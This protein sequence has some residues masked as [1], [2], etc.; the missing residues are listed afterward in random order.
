MPQQLQPYRPLLLAH[1]GAAVVL[2]LVAACSGGADPEGT[3][4]RIVRE[5]EQTLK[6]VAQNELVRDPELATRLGVLPDAAGY[7]FGGYLSDRS[8]AAFE[9][10]RLERLETLDVLVRTARPAP[11]SA[12][13]R[14]LDTV[15]AAHEAAERVLVSGHGAGDLSGFYPYVADHMRG[16]YL[17]VPELL[18][19]R[20]PMETPADVEA[21]LSRASQLA[22]AIDD[23]RRRLDA[24]ARAGVLPPAPILARMQALAASGALETPETSF[25]VQTFDNLLNGVEG[26]S[27]DARTQSAA[28][29]RTIF[30]GD[31]LP[32]YARLAEDITALAES[33]P[34]EPGVWQLEGGDA[35]YRAILDA[36]T[37]TRETPAELHTRGLAD[38][39][40]LT[41]E[42]DAAL[43]A[44]GLPDGTIAE[45][46]IF[47][48]QQPGQF[49]EDSDLGR[50]ALIERLTQLST[51]ATG[52]VQT[53]IG[54]PPAGAVT[55]SMI[56]F[57]FS[58][59]APSAVYTSRTADGRN[60]ARFE[61]NLLRL[62]DWPDFSLP[63][64]VYHETL[65][66][67]HL[68]SALA[69][70]QAALPLARQLIWNPGY[71]EGWASY[72]ETL[73]DEGGLYTDD[74]LG[75]IGYLQS[76]LLRAARV[77]ADTGIHQQKWTRERTIA[78]IQVTAG[79]SREAATDEVDRYSVWPG[80]AAAY[81]IGRQRI[82]DLRERAQRVLGPRFDAK[83]FHA[84]ILGGGP[85]PLDMVEADVTRWYTET[86]R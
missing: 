60:P 4:R 5:V 26:L 27:P 29:L 2:G 25:M 3:P 7:P 85:R 48:G 28:R 37:G 19:R 41:T 66:G 33:A 9:R 77:V 38:V 68:E 72:A 61:I 49:Y 24:D 14:H 6:T 31:I 53:Q 54:P 69:A 76:M 16:A 22:D 10:A 34:S 11:G 8:Q 36:Y 78:Y 43:A 45:R 71:G 50:A 39:K 81:W 82:L 67:H 52:L 40:R 62:A 84:A 59:A 80:Q 46:L 44:A 79:L 30:T 51:K 32:A 83:A 17:D 18:A 23:D 74:P 55:V 56:P 75:R 73:A 57:A 58:A 64:L 47:L 13:A 63:T 42:L 1:L 21:F 65:P 70:E 15:I 12:L 86:A 35:Y 20:Q